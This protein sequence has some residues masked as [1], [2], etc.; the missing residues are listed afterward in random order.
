MSDYEYISCANTAKLVRA[1][2]KRAFPATRFRVR[3]HT[4]AGGASIDLDYT[5]GPCSRFV[6]QVAQQYEGARF[7]GMVDLKTYTRH[8]L[9]PD[10][11]VRI[12][13]Y[14]PDG[15]S[16]QVGV[17]QGLP[18]GAR[19]VYF[20]ANFIFVHREGLPCHE[21]EPGHCLEPGSEDHERR[22]L[23]LELASKMK[24]R[25]PCSV[26]SLSAAGVIDV[27]A[28]REYC[29]TCEAGQTPG[30]EE[31]CTY[32]GHGGCQRLRRAS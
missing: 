19:Q 22:R 18:D 24:P 10:G 28:E 25:G 9:L 8:Y 23:S 5:G 26:A 32:C 11:S 29:Y 3:S 17:V 2:L 27:G 21:R 16:G 14:H 12:S 30:T 4:Y 31:A 15:I 7:D 1:A 6:K 20:A 13:S